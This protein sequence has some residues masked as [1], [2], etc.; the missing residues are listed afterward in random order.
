MKIKNKKE[1]VKKMTELIIIL[2]VIFL[3][4]IGLSWYLAWVSPVFKEDDDD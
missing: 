4:I 3:I 1:R 2:I